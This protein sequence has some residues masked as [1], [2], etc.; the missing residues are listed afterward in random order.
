MRNLIPMSPFYFLGLSIVI[1]VALLSF[2]P[3]PWLFPTLAIYLGVSLAHVW[4]T[5]ICLLTYDIKNQRETYPTTDASVHP[6]V[7]VP[8]YNESLRVLRNTLFHL[9]HSSVGLSVCVVNDGSTRH[10]ADRIKQCVNSVRYSA[11][12]SS[13]KTVFSF[14]NFEENRGKTAAIVAA[15]EH[16]RDFRYA[17]PN[18]PVILLDSDTIVYTHSIE[19]IIR[20]LLTPQIGGVSGEIIPVTSC[21]GS[22][23]LRLQSAYYLTAFNLTRAAQSALGQVNCCSG[24]FA[25]Y[26][27]DVLT[28]VLPDFASHRGVG[29][30]RRLTSL[31]LRAGYDVVYNAN[32][33]ALTEAPSTFAAFW[34]QQL[35]WRR[36]FLQEALFSLPWLW[37][38]KPLLWFET[39]VWELLWPLVSIGLIA[40][41]LI[42]AFSMPILLPGL[43]MGIISIAVIRNAPLL[44][45]LRRA[46]EHL[47][48]LLAFSLLSTLVLSWQTIFALATMRTR[49]WGTR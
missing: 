3:G 19:E 11:S 24:A 25:A 18:T 14:I 34:K 48:T 46:R 45:T 31:V 12:L 26:R 23:L 28:K 43:M 44:F 32:A 40:A 30:D 5:Y 39:L 21:K 42:H 7:I 20:P 27:Y 13:D 17:D 22:F 47:F 38:V 9:A 6:L 2:V 1:F 15:L 49:A 36:G 29:E 33:Y 37:R 35:R 41:S 8:V 16:V 4:Y 10:D